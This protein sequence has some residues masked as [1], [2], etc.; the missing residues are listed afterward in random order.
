MKKAPSSE[1]CLS[2]KPLPNHNANKP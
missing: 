2:E 1:P